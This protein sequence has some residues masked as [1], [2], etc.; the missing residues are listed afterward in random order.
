[1]FKNNAV[2]AFSEG[3]PPPKAKIKYYNTN[4]SIKDYNRCRI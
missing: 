3:N 1:M 4:G 2:R